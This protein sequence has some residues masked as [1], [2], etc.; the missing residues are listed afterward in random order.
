MTNLNARLSQGSGWTLLDATGIS[1]Q[2]NIV[3]NGQHQGQNRGFVL[4]PFRLLIAI[5]STFSHADFAATNAETG[6]LTW[7]VW[8]LQHGNPIVPGHPHLELGLAQPRVLGSMP[9]G[10][11]LSVAIPPNAGGYTVLFQAVNPGSGLV[12]PIISHTF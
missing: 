1:E 2:G 9:A 11:T 10:N 8:S 7:V 3:G 5:N 4:L 12:S 6:T